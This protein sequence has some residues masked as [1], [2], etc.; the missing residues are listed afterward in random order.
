MT[1]LNTIMK[2]GEHIEGKV[3]DIGCGIGVIGIALAKNFKIKLTLSDVNSNAIDIAK[4]NIG[5]HNVF[6]RLIESS[7]FDKIHDK[8]DYII[9]NPPIRAG[10]KVLFDIV[11]GAYHHLEKRGKIILVIRKDLG[12]DSLRK[13]MVEKFGNCTILGRDKG[14]YVL[15]STLQEELAWGDDIDKDQDIFREL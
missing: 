10:K 3:L 1:L 12:M 6:A 11:L 7:A 4:L 14:Y 9:T 8:F 15:S 5:R 13:A 2:T